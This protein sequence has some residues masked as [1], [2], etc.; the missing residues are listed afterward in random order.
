MPE[1]YENQNW[2]V[3]AVESEEVYRQMQAAGQVNSNELYLVQG[4]DTDK[5]DFIVEATLEYS[6][7]Y[8]KTI[9]SSYQIIKG[10]YDDLIEKFYND[11]KILIYAKITDSYADIQ[12]VSNYIN[13]IEVYS[14]YGYEDVI[15]L[16]HTNDVF[17]G[18][19]LD[20]N[21]TIGLYPIVRISTGEW[22]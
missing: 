10:S 6:L 2:V 22:Y 20:S 19:S 21:N 15:K 1:V 5:Y 16:Q 7:T 9:V 11:E 4:D 3:N 13:S 17:G 12:I 8:G 18:L 14:M